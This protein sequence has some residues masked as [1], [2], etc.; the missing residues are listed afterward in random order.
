MSDTAIRISESMSYDLKKIYNRNFT[1]ADFDKNLYE[2]L[3]KNKFLVDNDNENIN[4]LQ[5]LYH[6]YNES[7]QI[8]LI[9]TRQCNFNCP[10]CYEEHENKVMKY[11]TYKNILTFLMNFLKLKRL[12]SCTI[13]FFG[14]EPLLEIDN[15]IKFMDDLNSLLKMNNMNIKVYGHVT[16]NGYLLTPQNVEKLLMANIQTYQITVDGTAEF[17]NR[18]RILKNGSGTWNRII[19]NLLQMKNL[20]HNFSVQIRMNYTLESIQSIQEFCKFLSD[21]FDDSRFHFY[22]EAVKDFGKNESIEKKLY[23]FDSDISHTITGIAK[24]YNL[25][26]QILKTHSTLFGLKCYAAS[27]N[28][29]VFDYDGNIEK[30]TL[31]LD[32]DKKNIIGNVNSHEL[33]L[34]KLAEWTSFSVYDKCYKCS[35][36]PICYARKCPKTKPDDSYCKLIHQ[37]Y[38]DSIYYRFSQ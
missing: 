14:G 23:K 31:L 11:T 22:F 25:N 28:S 7:V 24:K 10:Y 19:S 37:I 33:D 3:I 35:I 21:N 36:L 2:D 15:M 26:M 29:L 13:C 1:Q 38:N 4:L 6:E 16:S 9:V 27:F 32:T 18:T 17:H 5:Y 30:C 20:K 12:N 34:Y 8:I